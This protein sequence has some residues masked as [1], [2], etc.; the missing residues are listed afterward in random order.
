MY[1]RIKGKY[2]LFH[3]KQ[4]PKGVDMKAMKVYVPPLGFQNMHRKIF[5]LYVYKSSH[6]MYFMV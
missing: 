2:A 3:V 4:N 5:F 6:G 1:I